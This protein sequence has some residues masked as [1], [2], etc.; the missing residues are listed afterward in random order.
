MTPDEFPVTFKS[1]KG[2]ALLLAIFMGVLMLILI[3]GV[4][5]GVQLWPQSP[6]ALILAIS[7]SGILFTGWLAYTCVRLSRHPN[8]LVIERTGLTLTVR[9]KTRVIPWQD[10]SWI[11]QSG[12]QYLD[13]RVVVLVLQP[14]SPTWI[15]N[16]TFPKDQI[17]LP[18]F[19]SDN[20]P[21]SDNLKALLERARTPG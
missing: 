4:V 5:A 18:F 13:P 19:D 10:V 2:G 3:P 11:G 16:R 21:G 9:A 14:N 12:T 17:R 6:A 20:W 15:Q 7:V 1:R 8:T